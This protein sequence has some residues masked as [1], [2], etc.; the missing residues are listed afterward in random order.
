MADQ[1]SWSGPQGGPSPTHHPV[2]HER[3]SADLADGSFGRRA[4]ARARWKQRRGVRGV[5]EGGPRPDAVACS[6]GS[7]EV[8]AASARSPTPAGTDKGFLSGIE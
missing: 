3:A 2:R 7:W 5:R 4:Y 1:A 6:S 8:H